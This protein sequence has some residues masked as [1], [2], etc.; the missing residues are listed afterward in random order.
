MSYCHHMASVVVVCRKHFNLLLWNHWAIWNQTW[1]EY[2]LGGSLQSFY[3]W[4][5][6][7]KTWPP[8]PIMCSDWLKFQRTPLKPLDQLNWN[9][10]R[11]MRG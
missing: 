9:L 7:F 6:E 10:V 3:F 11:M 2:Y 4:R 8:G 5:I 1:Q